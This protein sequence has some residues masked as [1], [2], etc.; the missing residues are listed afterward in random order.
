MSP[1]PPA[2]RLDYPRHCPE[3]FQRYLA[4]GAA[5][6]MDLVL[7]MLVDLR[8]SQLNGCAFCLDMHVKQARL[9][10]E[11]ELRLHHVAVWRESPLF[12]PKERAA[13]A[14]TEGLT[15]IAPGGVSDEIYAEARSHFSEGELA[16]LTFRVVSINGWNRLNVAFC[17][18]PGSRDAAFG[19]DQAVL[20]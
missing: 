11:R 17:T 13:L 5:F 20:E 7:A 14:W 12:S 15:H 3:L 16:E 8:A 1:C 4:F 19:L 6:H 2:P 10:G 18:L 9:L